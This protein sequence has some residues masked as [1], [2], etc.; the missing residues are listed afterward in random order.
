VSCSDGGNGGQGPSVSVAGI[1]SGSASDSSGP[2][3]MTWRLEDS[4][5]S[6]TGTFTM[7]DTA[8]GS[9]GQGTVTGT[10]SGSTFTFTLRVP[11]GGFTDP[12]GACTAEVSGSAQV[13]NT[14]MQ[15]SY[16]G[17]NSCS[18]V[19]SSGEFTLTKS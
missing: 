11:A 5:G 6:V 19:V 14:S 15:G 18:G 8:T 7:T 1:W 4:S 10:M 2:G 16:K 3:Q 12:W 17:N 13:A 9:V